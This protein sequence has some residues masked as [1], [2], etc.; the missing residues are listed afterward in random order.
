MFT[1]LKVFEISHA[2][3]SHAGARQAFIAQN[4]ANSDTPGYQTRDLRSFRETLTGFGATIGPSHSIGLVATRQS[5][6]HGQESAASRFPTAD[7]IPVGE[8][9]GK[10]VSIETEMLKAVEVKRQHDR[11]LAIYKSSLSVLRASLGQG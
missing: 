8:P 7:T 10:G 4:M 6:L 11:A 2:M 9:D 5:H 1:N 3:A